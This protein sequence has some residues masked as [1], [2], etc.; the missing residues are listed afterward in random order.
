MADMSRPMAVGHPSQAVQSIS[1]SQPG[2]TQ[3]QTQQNVQQGQ[4]QQAPK[5]PQASQV[6]ANEPG[7]TQVISSNAEHSSQQQQ[8]KHSQNPEQGGNNRQANQRRGTK[9]N[10]QS[11]PQLRSPQPHAQQSPMHHET[12]A[13]RNHPIDQHASKS[14]GQTAQSQ[15]VIQ[16][17][18]SQSQGFNKRAEAEGGGG[19]GGGGGTSVSNVP[20]HQQSQSATHHPITTSSNSPVPS[21][22]PPPRPDQAGG[23]PRHSTAGVMRDLK[24]HRIPGMMVHCHQPSQ[25]TT[26]LKQRPGMQTV[27]PVPQRFSVPA[28]QASPSDPPQQPPQHQMQ[29]HL[30]PQPHASPSVQAKTQTTGG[31]VQQQQS[32]QEQAIQEHSSKPSGRESVNLN[33]PQRGGAVHSNSEHGPDAQ[34]PP[35]QIESST[36]GPNG[37]RHLKV[38]D[39]LAYLEQVKQCFQDMPSIYNRFLDI[40]KEFKAQTIDT[41]EVIRRVSALFHGHRELILGFNTFLPPGYKIEHREDPESGC[42]TGFSNPGGNFCTLNGDDVGGVNQTQMSG[43]LT[44]NVQPDVTHSN[45]ASRTIDIS[46]SPGPNAHGNN[47]RGPNAGR[48][49][50]QGAHDPMGRGDHNYDHNREFTSPGPGVRQTDD[51]SQIDSRT[52][53]MSGGTST[54]KQEYHLS[55]APGTVQS[56]MPDGPQGAQHPQMQQGGGIHQNENAVETLAGGLGSPYAVS[57]QKTIEFDQAV[58]YVNKIKSRFSHNELVYK[59][60]LS[61]LQTYQKEQRSMKEV[62]EQVSELFR[63]HEDLLNEFSH[64]LPEATPH[65]EARAIANRNNGAGGSSAI[66]Q[67][68]GNTSATVKKQPVEIVT[69][70]MG[71]SNAEM[72]PSQTNSNMLKREKSGKS[73]GN[74]SR[75]TKGRGAGWGAGPA[76]GIVKNTA[77]VANKS[78]GPQKRADRKV[79]NVDKRVGGPGGLP[80]SNVAG[81][82]VMH[83]G[84]GPSSG[85]PGSGVGGG[86]MERGTPGLELQFFEELRSALGKEG[87]QNY[88]EFIKC[89]SLF[90]QEIIGGDEL[91][92]LA[93]GLLQNRKP[94]ADAFRA[95]LDRNDPNP[96]ETAVALLRKL[97]NES[98]TNNANA[99]T[100]RRPPRSNGAMATPGGAVPSDRQPL[101]PPTSPSKASGPNEH[102]KDFCRT[103]AGSSAGGDRDADVTMRNAE[104]DMR[105]GRNAIP[106]P[107]YHRKPLSEIGHDFG[108]KVGGSKSYAKLPSDVGNIP[109]SGMT[110]DD[111]TVLNHSFVA[112]GTSVA[113]SM[114]DKDPARRPKSGRADGKEADGTGSTVPGGEILSPN[115]TSGISRYGL[116]LGLALEEQR[117]DV[118][119]L[120]SRAQ[121]TV[122][123]LEKVE[124]GEIPNVSSLTGMDLKPIELIYQDASLDMLEL[125]RT[126][127]TVTLPIILQRLKQRIADWHGSRKRLEQIWKTKRFSASANGHPRTW[128]RSEMMEDLMIAAEAS[129]GEAAASEAN[130]KLMIID[131]EDDASNVQAAAGDDATDV[132]AHSDQMQ[133]DTKTSDGQVNM[134]EDRTK[135]RCR[136]VCEDENLNFIIDILWFAF[137]WAANGKE[138]GR[139]ANDGVDF[140]DRVYK[141]L[142][143]CEKRGVELFVC[144]YLY[145]Y[146]RLVSEASERIKFIV[147]YDA[148]KGANGKTLLRML[149]VSKDVLTGKMLLSGYDSECSK[150]FGNDSR[151]STTLWEMQLRDLAVILKRLSE[152]ATSMVDHPSA[153]EMLG[154]CEESVKTGTNNINNANNLNNNNTNKTSQAS[155]MQKAVNVGIKYSVEVVGVKATV[156]REVKVMSNAKGKTAGTEKAKEVVKERELGLEFRWIAK[157][158]AGQYE[159]LDV[160]NTNGGIGARTTGDKDNKGGNGNKRDCRG[161]GSGKKGVRSQGVNNNNNNGNGNGRKSNGINELCPKSDFARFVRREYNRYVWLNKSRDRYVRFRGQGRHY[162]TLADRTRHLMKDKCMRY[163]GLDAR[164]N[165]KTGGIK[166]VSGSHDIYIRVPFKKHRRGVSS[167]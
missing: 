106:N 131:T 138:D 71:S 87:E 112:K 62:Y 103:G 17:Q 91:L 84:D 115:G 53:A 6:Q 11:S 22:M 27:Q 89:L 66:N 156:A 118:D 5:T 116:G 4:T 159:K 124:S 15:P 166:Y 16:E 72:A 141:L 161:D 69:G 143:R 104:E 74:K 65:A 163:D 50:R 92:R 153:E 75:N 108:T 46:T 83:S 133:I 68:G 28:P 39:A 36:Q 19:R 151:S 30:Q 80:K 3:A 105:S 33:K 110:A 37:Y 150:L 34:P 2:P 31:G 114:L 26:A 8:G 125:L 111:R 100:N 21:M 121:T 129:A 10:N 85:A 102:A 32:K 67:R 99:A 12:H 1:M 142:Q 47:R 109:S 145:E 165:D 98:G 119:L 56:R 60:F 44:P 54:V 126:N 146:I 149:E 130:T 113:N 7:S 82:P 123:K 155:R 95:F 42:I 35:R 120:I 107:V 152:A 57:G 158:N 41:S 61:I 73:T 136:L 162:G 135:V 9:N 23:V 154:M 144:E 132:D 164:V 93:E 18:Q 63:D 59:R 137:E 167:D 14:L 48:S 128:K 97:K 134:K 140:I 29:P 45:V 20:M 51:M 86:A 148:E 117:M 78:R 43:Q 160:S 101:V 13:E 79:A 58:R 127:P 25:S 52:V 81:G 55:N 77:A 157:H 40:M 96:S 147:D 38:E 76:G 70:E 90:C 122:S 139:K 49:R 24:N 88:A 64:F 94:L